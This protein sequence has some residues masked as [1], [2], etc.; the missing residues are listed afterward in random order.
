MGCPIVYQ[1]V[2]ESSTLYASLRNDK[3]TGVLFAGC[4]PARVVVDVVLC[5]VGVVVLN[6]F[7]GCERKAL[8]VHFIIPIGYRGAFLVHTGQ[9]S[10]VLL[11]EKDGVVTCVI[12]KSGVLDVRGDGPF[13]YWHTV[14]ASFDNGTPIPIGSYE[15]ERLVPGELALVG[16]YARWRAKL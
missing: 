14:R 7:A 16:R 3:R 4:P 11:Q 9:S 1:A 2:P 8:C 6:V 15:A 12:P 5:V 10:G 13:Y